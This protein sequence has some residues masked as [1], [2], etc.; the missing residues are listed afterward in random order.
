MPSKR[1]AGWRADWRHFRN[2]PSAPTA[3]ACWGS[4]RV[5]SPMR[6]APSISVASRCSSQVR[7][8]K[9]PDGLPGV[10]AAT[11]SSCLDN[12][13]LDNYRGAMVAEDVERS[14]AADDGDCIAVLVFLTPAEVRAGVQRKLWSPGVTA[15]EATLPRLL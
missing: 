1:P 5:T 11:A 7:L 9:G 15:P 13:C 14:A 12:Y 6:C 3:A 10:A 4:G 8:G 2:A